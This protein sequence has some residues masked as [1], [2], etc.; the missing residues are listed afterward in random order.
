M[1]LTR[2]YPTK[3]N[4]IS[5]HSVFSSFYV[6]VSQQGA[7]KLHPYNSDAEKSV[8]YQ[9]SLPIWSIWNVLH[10]QNFVV[11]MTL[12]TRMVTRTKLVETSQHHCP[13][14]TMLA[15]PQAHINRV[16]K[17]S[18]CS[19]LVPTSGSFSDSSVN[20]SNCS[21]DHFFFFCNI[22]TMH[23]HTTTWVQF[24]SIS[25][26]DKFD[27]TYLLTDKCPHFPPLPMLGGW[28]ITKIGNI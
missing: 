14:N 28:F 18:H 21:S 8:F 27:G 5:V 2:Q 15:G 4:L 23:M 11:M 1:V 24:F 19:W 13:T 12:V 17:P 16:W 22:W 9:K 7:W 10:T 25:Q 26:T 20:F 3:Q 6:W